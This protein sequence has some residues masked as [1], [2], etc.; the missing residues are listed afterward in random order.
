MDH[1]GRVRQLEAELARCRHE[2]GE[3]SAGRDRNVS[4][5]GQAEGH[6]YLGAPVA[7]IIAVADTF[8]AMTSDRP[9]R[10]GLPDDAALAEIERCRGT[11]FDAAC[12]DVFSRAYGKGLVR[13]RRREREEG[14]EKRSAGDH[15][16]EGA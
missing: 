3:R 15:L 11:Q 5:G 7:R 6:G 8:D 16:R 4:Y 2:I 14:R 12:V 1:E 10:A 13:S 9:Y